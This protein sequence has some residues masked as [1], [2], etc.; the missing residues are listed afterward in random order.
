MDI[1]KQLEKIIDTTG[2]S[3]KK[4]AEMWEKWQE[5]STLLVKG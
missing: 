2:L 5:K 4:L 1:R 3:D